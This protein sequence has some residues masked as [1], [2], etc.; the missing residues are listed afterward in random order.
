MNPIKPTIKT[1]ILPIIIIILMAI[2]SYFFYQSFPDEVPM[3]WN[4]QGEVDDYGSKAMGAFLMPAMAF[5]MYLL[6]LALPLMDPKK[7]RYKEFRKVYHIFKIL[8]LSF[9]L[10]IYLLIATASFGYE[11]NIGAWVS[12]M[13]GILFILL[14]NYFGKIKPNWFMGIRTPWTLSSEEVWN[15]THRLGGKV[16]ILGGLTMALITLFPPAWQSIVFVVLILTIVLVPI[17]YSFLLFR[18][19]NK[20]KDL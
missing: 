11:V 10:I 18:K 14:G 12:A 13:V 8:L 6:F 2:L 3:H 1:E 7:E 15:K 19:N 9:F 5:G 17:V 16:F 4:I 20:N